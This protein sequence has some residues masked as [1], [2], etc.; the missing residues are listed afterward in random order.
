MIDPGGTWTHNPQLRRLMPYPLG[1]WAADSPYNTVLNIVSTHTQG[2]KWLPWDSK[3]PYNQQYNWASVL[4]MNSIR[5]VMSK[6]RHASGK[7]DPSLMPM[8]RLLL[9]FMSN[10]GTH[11]RQMHTHKTGLTGT[12]SCTQTH[13]DTHLSWN[14]L[15]NRQGETLGLWKGFPGFHILFLEEHHDKKGLDCKLKKGNACLDNGYQIH[16]QTLAI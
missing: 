13:T 5:V 11:R 1:H 14:L 6:L 9:P 2:Q 8:E 15:I 12:Y 4:Y 3:A 7:K 10:S 16:H